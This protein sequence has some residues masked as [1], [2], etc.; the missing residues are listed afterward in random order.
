MA[1]TEKDKIAFLR[2]GKDV[3]LEFA[4]L[5]KDALS[6]SQEEDIKDHV[7][8]KISIGVDVKGLKKINRVDE[9]VN[10]NFHWVEIKNV[11][12]KDGWLYGK[13]DFFA[14]EIKDYWIIVGREDLQ[15]F[16]ADKCKKKT[17]TNKPDLYTLYRRVGRKDIITMITSYDLCYI[18]TA[19]IKK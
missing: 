13:A 6:T 19:I 1:F 7:D 2:K 10:E 8:V 15:K 18:S 3:E 5:F 11:Q 17:W 16:I 4:S 14:F 12:G 9:S